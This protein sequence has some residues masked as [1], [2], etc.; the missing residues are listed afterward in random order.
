MDYYHPF[1]TLKFYLDR[2]QTVH[3]KYALFEKTLFETDQCGEEEPE[4]VLSSDFE[5]PGVHFSCT[6][7]ASGRCT[8][9]HGAGMGKSFANFAESCKE[10]DNVDYSPYSCDEVHGKATLVGSCK[11][12]NATIYYYTSHLQCSVYDGTDKDI[13]NE[14]VVCD[15]KSIL[16]GYAPEWTWG[17]ACHVN[18]Q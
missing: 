5:G 12:T 8:E 7:R 13:D 3:A 1:L 11:M 16:L 14:R 4:K 17:P 15:V 18:G 6:I 2:L 10:S 9:Y